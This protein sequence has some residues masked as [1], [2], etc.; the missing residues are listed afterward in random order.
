[1]CVTWSGKW[2]RT[3]RSIIAYKYVLRSGGVDLGGF[4]Y[5]SPYEFRSL[6]V[7]GYS[8]HSVK[9]GPNSAAGKIL[10][11]HLG[12]LTRS[13]K[14]GIYLYRDA[15]SAHYACRSS[16]V[17][18][19]VRIPKGTLVRLGDNNQINALA[20]IPLEIEV[21]SLVTNACKCLGKDND[22]SF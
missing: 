1:M 17:I 2:R 11:Y 19:K 12:E 10:Y 13:A 22:W 5:A 8:R 3:T 20:V 4:Y 6:Q 16:G 21:R 14:P 9:A 18:L 7:N 15:M